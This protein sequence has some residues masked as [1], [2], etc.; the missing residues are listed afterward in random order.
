MEPVLE[1]MRVPE[2]VYRDQENVPVP[3]ETVEVTVSD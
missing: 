1:A 3:P 2:V